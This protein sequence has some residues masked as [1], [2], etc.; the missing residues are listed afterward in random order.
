MGEGTMLA[1][2]GAIAFEA[3][4]EQTLKGK[5]APV[6]AWRALRVVAER[7]GRKRAEM[8]EAPFVGRDDE[9]RLLKDFFHATGRDHRSRTISITGQGGIGKSRLAWEF[10]KYLD[11][12]VETVYWHHG[13]SPSI[14]AGLSFWA[15]GEM[16][17]SR[18]GLVESDDD[19]TT[20][21]KLAAELPR[22][23]PNADERRWIEPALLTLLGVENEAHL[24]HEQLFGAWRTFIE[25]IAEQGTV[26]LVFEDMHWADDGMVAFVEHLGEW[27]RTSPI[28]LVTLARP[29]LLERHP[30]W[31]AGRRHFTSVPLEPLAAESMRALLAG[32]V[33]G[34]PDAAARAIIDRADG[35]PLYAVETVRML[36][37]EGRLTAGEDGT[38][39]P[40][41]DLAE[42]AVPTTLRSLI[43][44][45]LDALDPADRS[46]LQAASVVGQSFSLPALLAVSADATGLEQRLASLVHRELLVRD[47][48]PR[49]PER[50]QY[51]FVQAFLREVAYGTLAKADRRRLHLAAARYF[52]ASGDDQVA[53]ALA[54]QYLAAFQATPAG[55][56]A[57]ALAGQARIALRSAG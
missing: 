40:S 4:G 47:V 17:R 52:E 37:A 35:I 6:P 5:Q 39:H 23:V 38:Y 29:E 54:A 51:R 11:G 56:E 1:A 55:P 20:R 36:V 44:A 48:D 26:V 22:W 9:L 2:G 27:S 43:A 46:A 14:G 45:R 28:L 53:G 24:G 42:L 19:A 16:V 12:L 10:E 15:L 13:R 57:D 21:T 33:P 30:E 31:G 25:R 3:A 18:F 34:L 32:L 50:G 41:G 49:S 8:L 7:G